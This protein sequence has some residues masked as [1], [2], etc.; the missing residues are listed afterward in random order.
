MKVLLD[1]NVFVAAL[2][3]QHAQHDVAAAWL[4]AITHKTHSGFVA[5]H[6]LAEI[7]AILTR[8]PRDLAVTP[9]LALDA[10]RR[11]VLAV[12]EAVS[13]SAAD[14]NTLL[15]H[16]AALGITGGTIYDALLL[17]AASLAQVDLV[18]TMNPRHFR[19][20]NPLLADKIVSS[21]E[22]GP[23]DAGPQ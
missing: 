5:A 10:I 16:V 8:L 9:E 1:T 11:N 6:S 12:C 4:R 20:A 13:L 22:R 19:R 23:N 15:G 2:T 14:Y 21:D 17:H 18:V 3:R 7:Y